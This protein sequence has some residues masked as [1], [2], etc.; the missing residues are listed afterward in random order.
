MPDAADNDEANNSKDERGFDNTGNNK[1]RL[2]RY[3]QYYP[4]SHLRKIVKDVGLAMGDTQYHLD[5]L[6]KSGKIKS[7]RI[8]LH[9]RYYPV[10]IHD[11]TSE[12]ILAFLR[13]ETS[14]DI[15]VYLIEHPNSTQGDI[16]NFKHFSSPTISWHMSKLIEAGI[17]MSAR[18]WKVVRY[19]IKEDILRNI[20]SNLK[21]YHPSVWNNLASRLTEL[22]LELSISS[23]TTSKLKQ[24][25][26]PDYTTKEEDEK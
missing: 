19:S 25:E 2:Y 22:F 20:A 16:A 9:R 15:L 4:G 24:N 11:E 5:I 14:R 12:I 23:G 18:Q 26:D 7:R 21:T 13:Q 6:E 3:I 8:G 17:V 1:I 10:A